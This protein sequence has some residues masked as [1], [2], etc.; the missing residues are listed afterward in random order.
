MSIRKDHLRIF[1]GIFVCVHMLAGD[2]YW[3][4]IESK[5][6]GQTVYWN[7][8]G[9]ETRINDYIRW[10]SQEAQKQY[11]IKVQHV[12]LSD[13]AEAVTRV[14]AEKAAGKTDR[15]SVDLIWIN[16]ENFA[17]MKRHGLLYGPFT[18]QLPNFR[19]VDTDSKPTLTDF[20][21]PVDGLEAPWSMAQ[22]VF[23]YDSVSIPRP[24]RTPKALLEWAKANPGRFTY[25][26]P[27][28]FLG[29]TFLKQTF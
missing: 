22:F 21:V 12:K 11:G 24:P 29:T 27:P 13:T 20:T 9:G 2:T 18:G 23:I 16:G 4:A 14:L 26:Q 28:D 19:L 10:A 1:S 25:P 6:R 7:A 5:A 8:W 15:G 3:S 17:A